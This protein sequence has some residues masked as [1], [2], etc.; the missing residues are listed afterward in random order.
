MVHGKQIKDTSVDL[1][2]INP[3][4]G[5]LLTLV[6]TSKIQVNAA[7]TVGI[8]LVNKDYVDALVT[9]LDF[10]ESVRV[11]SNGAD[12]DIS[13]APASID[14]VTLATS[15]RI[16][17]KDQTNGE[18]NGIYIFNGTGNSLTRSEDANTN[19]EVTAGMFM[20]VEEGTWADTGWVLSTNNPIVLDTTI[21]DF[22]QFSAAGVITANNGLTKTG[23]NIQLGGSLV[24]N[25]TID[26]TSTY[27][28]IFDNIINYSVN[29][30]NTIIDSSTITTI[31]GGTS[32]IELDTTVGIDIISGVDIINTVAN[33]YIVNATN[34]VNLN[35]DTGIDI[36][37]S[38]GNVDILA[39]TGIVN[40]DAE[41]VNIT[42]TTNGILM[43]ST[44]FIELSA[45][46]NII[47]GSVD[48]TGTYTGSYTVNADDTTISSSTLTT[49]DGD[50]VDINAITSVAINS[51]AVTIDGAANGIVVTTNAGGL[52]SLTSNDEITLSS[53]EDTTIGAA[54]TKSIILNADGGAVS[55]DLFGTA[56]SITNNGSD[57]SMV[58]TDT[59]NSKGLVYATDYSG[60][61]TPE[62]LVSKRYV[63]T[64]TGGIETL[65]N[66]IMVA[67]V[68]STQGD[69]IAAAIAAE[70]KNDSYVQVFI[71]GVK[72]TVGNGVDTADV[73]FADPGD[74]STA[75]TIA[76]ITTGD[77]LVR[78]AGLGYDTDATDIVEYDY[79]V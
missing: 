22:T 57:N 79:S 40:I 67:L 36:T 73:Y 27:H 74:L 63:D 7:P 50:N 12:V 2:K 4:T 71:N 69:Q 14:G 62:S 52:I 19:T 3:A 6:G 38:T 28:M 64:T 66:K 8:D 44:D 49:I 9:G 32:S 15:D 61:F 11:A 39:T 17:L 47:E 24:Q 45:V 10:K 23:N 16:L 58:V 34:L 55:I 43:T 68:A 77:V 20:F 54:A 72:C 53:T 75:K 1:V 48:F 30:T 35:G 65:S 37:S 59:T 26:G 46:G 56:Q 42:S 25:T 13:T 76:T 60:N 18:E 41:D 31:T 70:P 78:G 51:A 33:D 21:L 29:S 5:Q